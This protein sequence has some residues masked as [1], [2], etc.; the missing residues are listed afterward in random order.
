MTSALMGSRILAGASLVQLYTGLVY[1]GPRLIARIT[2]ELVALLERDGFASVG[3]A[4][5]ARLP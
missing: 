4:A 5:G 2:R 3:E 1:E